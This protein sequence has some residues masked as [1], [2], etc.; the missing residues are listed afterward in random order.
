MNT[1]SEARTLRPE[2]PVIP[3]EKHTSTILYFLIDEREKVEKPKVD[4]QALLNLAL[5]AASSPKSLE[6]SS[7]TRSNLESLSE[8]IVRLKNHL[9]LHEAKKAPIAHIEKQLFSPD[10]R[11]S[12]T[13]LPTAGSHENHLFSKA[14]EQ[15]IISKLPQAK[16]NHTSP[17]PIKVVSIESQI[18]HLSL[19][20]NS[21]SSTPAFKR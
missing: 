6:M 15:S 14:P 13:R 8:I 17:M 21:E 4:K 20:N 7:E 10:I 5:Y 16:H 3:S 9:H 11:R 12:K 19:S 18:E 1:Y 2:T